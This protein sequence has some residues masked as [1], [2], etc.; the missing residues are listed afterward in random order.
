MIKILSRVGIAVLLGGFF[1]P[2]FA[3]DTNPVTP[4]VNGADLG[5]S[6]PLP[7]QSAAAYPL[8][9]TAITGNASGS[10]GAVVGTLAAATGKMTYICGFDI[11]AIGGTASVGPVTVAGIVGSSM[12][13]QLSASAAGVSLSKTFT[14][15]IPGSA[16]NTPITV[17]TTADGTATAVNVNTSGYQQ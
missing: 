10:T 12:T 3:F 17:T 8:G 14:P 2:A 13:Y 15:C 16:S 7:T 5:V 9:A 11:S 4:L 1:T 6:N